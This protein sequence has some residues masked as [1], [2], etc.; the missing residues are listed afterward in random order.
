MLWKRVKLYHVRYLKHV[1]CWY[2]LHFPTSQLPY[3][4]ASSNT[5]FPSPFPSPSLPFPPSKPS[6]PNSQDLDHENDDPFQKKKSVVTHQQAPLGSSLPPLYNNT[7]EP[8]QKH[9]T[10]ANARFCTCS[11]V[12]KP[13]PGNVLTPVPLLL[14]EKMTAL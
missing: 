1:G 8:R 4:L 5:C 13:F 14:P 11:A 9:Q 6:H 12:A 3:V 10:H 7:V 2:L